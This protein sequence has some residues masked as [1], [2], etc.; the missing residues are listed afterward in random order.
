MRDDLKVRISA[1]KAR[2]GKQ[3]QEEADAK[4]KA[5]QEAAEAAAKLKREEEEAGRKRKSKRDI[6][7]RL[8]GSSL[9]L[10]SCMC[11]QHSLALLAYSSATCTSP[12]VLP[13]VVFL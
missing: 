2:L 5:D 6:Q 3:R 9:E 11:R 12:V 10:A 4:A 13:V 7:R 1:E 8:K